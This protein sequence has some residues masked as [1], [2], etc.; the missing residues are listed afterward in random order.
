MFKRILIAN[1]GEIALRII[2]ACKELGIETVAVYSTADISSLHV[3]FADRRVCI[4]GPK[5]DESYLNIPAVIS[6]AE[7]TG[8]EAIHPG[9]GFLAENAHFAEICEE[10][11]IKFIGPTPESIRMMGNKSEARKIMAKRN[12][13]IIPGSR[14]IILTPD[15]AEDIANQIGYP[16]MLKAS[17]GGGGRGMRI[18]RNNEEVRKEYETARTEAEASFGV[19]DLYIEKHIEQPRHIE[20]QILADEHGNMIH[21]G[22][23]ECSIQRRHQKLIEESPSPVV[24]KDLRKAMTDVAL[25][26]ARTVDYF[27]AGT[28]EFLL[29]KNMNFYFMEMN[30]RIQVEHPV[31][32]WVTG[33][34]IVKEQIRIA[35]GQKL[36]YKQDDIQFRGHSIECRVNAETPDTFMPSPGRITAFNTPKGPGVRVD[37]A[38]YEGAEI[39]PYY[40][41]MIAKVAVYGRD[42]DEAINR[43]R[44][45]LDMMVLEG[46]HSNI[47]MHLKILEDSDFKKGNLSTHFMERY[48]PNKNQK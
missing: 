40:D 7:I 17:A 15:E 29:D 24:G 14:D 47:P 31:T 20:V 4:G 48:M 21:L 18:A 27:N 28:I 30:T 41:S 2:W 33:V 46:I 9:Y 3:H 16:V 8:A 13:P 38:M 25:K 22:E 34:D 36:L 44:R 5:S 1:R 42:R 32:E 19:P 6:A 35:D 26:A 12:I 11:K 39:P 43:M 37:T 10:C 45:A 23:R